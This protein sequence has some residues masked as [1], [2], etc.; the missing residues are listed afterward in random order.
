[1]RYKL[2]NLHFDVTE[3]RRLFKHRSKNVFIYFFIYEIFRKTLNMTVTYIFCLN[4]IFNIYCSFISRPLL[5]AICYE[6]LYKYEKLAGLL[7]HISNKVENIFVS[8][9]C[10]L[11]TWM[12]IIHWW[13]SASLPLLFLTNIFFFFIIIFNTNIL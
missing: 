8:I 6:A 5:L 1:M 2:L 4:C 10:I 13:I 12:S 11:N 9:S 7:N 3:E